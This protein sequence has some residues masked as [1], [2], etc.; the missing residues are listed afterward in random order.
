MDSSQQKPLEKYNTYSGAFASDLGLSIL[1]VT[2]SCGYVVCLQ[3]E[4]QHEFFQFYMI[5]F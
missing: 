4:G 3:Q 2:M 1:R 5:K